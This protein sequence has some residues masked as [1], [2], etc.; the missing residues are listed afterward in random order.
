M[1]IVII[2]EHHFSNA[3]FNRINVN[4]LISST[5]VHI[6]A[7]SLQIF[8]KNGHARHWTSVG[9]VLSSCRRS[10]KKSIAPPS[11]QHLL[12][13]RTM[14]PC[15]R[16]I[17]SRAVKLCHITPTPLYRTR[18]LPRVLPSRSLFSPKSFPVH[19]TIGQ[20]NFS[21]TIQPCANLDTVTNTL[22]ICCPGCGAYAQT[23]E[24]DELGYYGEGRRRK[25]VKGQPA[26]KEGEKD[27]ENTDE[28]KTEG[29]AAAERIEKVLRDA[30]EKGYTRP[31]PKRMWECYATPYCLSFLL[32]MGCFR[33]SH[34]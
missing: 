29:E 28:L 9:P 12:K 18:L 11:P 32:T 17:A 27:A 10:D 4:L 6:Y 30:E 33:W 7:E 34:A 15:L 19:S 24:P 16:G 22:P 21:S 1:Y 26:P 14:A 31:A 2:S 20:R 5:R 8:R 23:I 25:F 3:W 13:H